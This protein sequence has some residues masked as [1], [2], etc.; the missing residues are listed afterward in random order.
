MQE[1]RKPQKEEKRSLEK[2]DTENMEMKKPEE[3]AKPKKKKIISV[4]RPQ[5]ATS[6][7]AKE[8]T[9]NQG[10]KKDRPSRGNG[11]PARRTNY[12]TQKAI[13]IP[14]IFSDTATAFSLFS[15]FSFFSTFKD[16]HWFSFFTDL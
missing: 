13:A 1:T 3:Q 16:F 14:I 6:K 10:Q 15:I 9:K 11:R 12:T 5:N 2:K 8:F 7:E 4:V